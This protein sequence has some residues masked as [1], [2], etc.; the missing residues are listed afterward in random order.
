MKK[1]RLFSLLMVVCL[2]AVSLFIFTPSI[3][4]VNA[5]EKVFTKSEIISSGGL[6]FCV[7]GEEYFTLDLG[8]AKD[9]IDGRISVEYFD[10]NTGNKAMIE[11]GNGDSTDENTVKIN[12]DGTIRIKKHPDIDYL[13]KYEMTSIYI[14]P[15]AVDLG[16]SDFNVFSQENHTYSTGN[17]KCTHC[18]EV[19]DCAD[20]NPKDHKCDI[21]GTEISSCEDEDGDCL[22]DICKKIVYDKSC[23]T[24]LESNITTCADE[25]KCKIKL[26]NSEDV[27]QNVH[28][29]T[30]VETISGRKEAFVCNY[31][32]DG[33]FTDSSISKDGTFIIPSVIQS[34]SGITE[35]IA[36]YKSIRIA[37]DIGTGS[38][39]DHGEIYFMNI[40]F[41]D[42]E[43]KDP[44]DH[45]CDYGC[46]KTLSS[47]EDKDPKDHK[48]DTC[49]KELSLC[50][51]VDPVDHICDICGTEMSYCA[52]E[53]PKDHI[54]DI[55]KKS[56]G[57]KCVD[58]DRDHKCDTCG[59][60]LSLCVDV[61]KDH[62]CE[63]CNAE[64]SV[65]V[66]NDKNH[67]C[68]LCN[69]KITN[70]GDFDDDH[71]CDICHLELTKC[72]DE[73]S[74]GFCDI[75]GVSLLE[76]T[77]PTE[78]ETTEEEEEIVVEDNE[79]N[80]DKKDDTKN[81]APKTGDESNIVFYSSILL[82]SLIGF[83]SILI[84]KRRELK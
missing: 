17:H 47:C 1:K 77:K 75:C 55:C 67:V 72:M 21:C 14:R 32:S 79:G 53:N 7:E 45:K 35:K 81:K 39:Y 25:L 50:E 31:I 23:V 71:K 42:H 82:L 15:G 41:A 64:V 34:D 4:S 65:C 43:D 10:T 80:D 51:D 29:V 5:S 30:N 36:K 52:D 61:N 46:G 83:I 38:D 19:S 13:T 16:I 24:G 37:W 70:C 2:L 84:I 69:E 3:P 54:C 33:S 40:K 44:K 78:E 49:G 74:D 68:D 59:K 28:I 18:G 57:T 58:T 11:T 66:D 27:L 26:T 22:C 73:N 76:E 60:E 56:M 63:V 9:D 12:D 6:K 62:K 48:C 20:V 8:A